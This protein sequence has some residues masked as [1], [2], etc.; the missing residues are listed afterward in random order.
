[1]SGGDDVAFLELVNKQF[2]K[3][4]EGP[5]TSSIL[6][7][8]F[9]DMF[10]KEGQDLLGQYLGV[11]IVNFPKLQERTS[12]SVNVP[13][14][15]RSFFQSRQDLVRKM[16]D[17]KSHIRYANLKN[18]FPV[19]IRT[20]EEPSDQ[21]L[22]VKIN[23]LQKQLNKSREKESQLLSVIQKMNGLINIALK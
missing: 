16:K 15:V 2:H 8:R 18:P 6:C 20:I 21:N 19:G 12:G 7:L 23:E 22:A 9:Q 10:T 13:N 17:T 11:S 14:E 5:V 1:M 4:T 3:W